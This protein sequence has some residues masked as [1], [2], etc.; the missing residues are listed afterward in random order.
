MLRGPSWSY[1]VGVSASQPVPAE[2][3]G[4]DRV[5]PPPPG[6]A[7]AAQPAPAPEHIQ[8]PPIPPPPPLFAEPASAAAAQPLIVPSI[9]ITVPPPVESAGAVETVKATTVTRPVESWTLEVE[10]GRTFQLVERRVLLG[11]DPAARP[12]AQEI[13]VHDPTRTVSKTHAL[14]E[15]VDD[16][17]RVTDLGSVNGV[18][19]TDP[20]GTDRILA[21][22]VPEPVT[23]GFALGRV[24]LQLRS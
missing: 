3:G 5:P 2:S 10:G 6:I 14:L 11:R 1:A 16:V 17:W 18:L 20:D 9:D 22:G 19:V 13:V 21:P 12:G 15:L 24:R 23:G 7:P 4:V 8:P